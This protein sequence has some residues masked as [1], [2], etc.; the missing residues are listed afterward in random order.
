MMLGQSAALTTQLH[1]GTV[2]SFPVPPVRGVPSMCEPMIQRQPSRFWLFTG[3]LLSGT[4]AV[5]GFF[6][7]SPLGQVVWLDIIDPPKPPVLLQVVLFG[8]PLLLLLIGVVAHLTLELGEPSSSTIE[9]DRLLQ[10]KQQGTFL[11]R[12]QRIRESARRVGHFTLGMDRSV[13]AGVVLPSFSGEVLEQLVE[14]KRR[15]EWAPRSLPSLH[16]E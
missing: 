10:Q 12:S 6:V 11:Q 2:H 4:L 3:L 13:P 9:L 16:P 8:P 5:T 1:L 15:G 7:G 14:R